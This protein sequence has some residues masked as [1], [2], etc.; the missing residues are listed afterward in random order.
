MA[1]DA[2]MRFWAYVTSAVMI[3]ALLALLF[4]FRAPEPQRT[5]RTVAAALEL[6]VVA[7]TLLYFRPT[8]VRL[9][10]GHGAGL[11][12]DALR[13]TVSRWVMWSRL[14]ILA[15]FVAWCA[16]LGALTLS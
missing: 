6:A 9:F 11:S 5:W 7:S 2:G 13:S 14:R 16:A 12:S 10:M 1:I 3:L 4:G 15:S 8:L